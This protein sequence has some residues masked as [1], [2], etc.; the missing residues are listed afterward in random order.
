[1][2]FSAYIRKLW[3]DHDPVIDELIAKQA[4]YLRSRMRVELVH[5]WQPRLVDCRDCGEMICTC[6]QEEQR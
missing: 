4:D 5:Q 1:M 2:S 6:R 3:V